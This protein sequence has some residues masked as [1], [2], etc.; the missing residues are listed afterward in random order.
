MRPCLRRKENEDEVW[1]DRG[2]DGRDI[3]VIIGILSI[4]G[5][6]KLNECVTAIVEGS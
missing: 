1:K 6:A 3:H 2:K 4:A 5:A